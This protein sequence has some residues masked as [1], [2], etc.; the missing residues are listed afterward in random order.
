[1]MR[2]AVVDIETTG[3][4]PQ[5]H[6]ITEI[7][8]VLH[9][10]TEIE[11]RFESLVNPFQPI[12]PFIVGM[13]GITNAM[14]M[15]APSFAEI[16][17]KIF[18]LLSNRVFVAH[19]VNFD[20][21]FVK[22]H[23][24]QSGFDLQTLKL[25]TIRLSR[26]AFPGFP[27]YGLGHLCRQLNIPIHNRHRAGGD[28]LAT[29][30][31]LDLVLKN[32][33]GI[34][35]KEMLQKEHKEYLLPANLPKHFIN[36]LPTTPGVYY[37]HNNKGKVVYVGKAKNLKKRVV[38]HFSGL[39]ISRKRQDF[40]REIYTI[41]HVDCPTEF[42]ASI[43]ESIEIKRLWPAYNKSQK[44]YEQNW[45]IYAF[46]DARGYL[47]LAID[48]KHKQ[49][50]PI[51]AFSLLVDAHRELWRLVKSFELHPSLCFLDKTIPDELPEIEQYNRQVNQ[52]LAFIA[53]EKES[54]IIREKKMAILVEK[55]KFIGMGE[56]DTPFS[57]EP[58]HSDHFESLKL[59]VTPYAE[60][61]VIKGMIRKYTERY[62]A[63]IVRISYFRSP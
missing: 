50:Q 3:G 14:V 27:K 31:V 20:F 45:G 9:N 58:L 21:S 1:M 4:F 19:N 57:E 34:L 8:I 36:Q 18:Q 38:S 5:Q 13:T 25:C 30:E 17:P 41:S 43:F 61:E 28:A 35:I 46:E 40:I 39:D 10:G 2:F 11:G 56:V 6:G 55:G 44:K 29:A 59:V 24:Q 15:A 22:H 49:T 48:K 37:F 12:P 60:N 16:A 51:V 23:L 63:K 42:I 47:R 32:N 53:A 7:A 62:P 26:K 33:G 54:F 52:A